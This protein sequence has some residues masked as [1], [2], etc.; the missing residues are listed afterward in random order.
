MNSR[1]S[2][3]SQLFLMEFILVVMFFALCTGICLSAFVKA[4]NISREGHQLNEALLL[5]QSMAETIKAMDDVEHENIMKAVEKIN[6][7]NQYFVKVEDRVNDHMLEADIYVYNKKNDEE[8]ICSIY[9]NK[10]LPREVQY[11]E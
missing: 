11:A 4:N 7:E 5:A 1:K 8:Q 6:L 10:Y 3:K 9:I 2:S